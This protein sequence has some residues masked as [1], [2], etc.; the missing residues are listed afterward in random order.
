MG[1]KPRFSILVAAYNV[2]KYIGECL[3]SLLV[4]TFNDYEVVVIDD[5][6]TDETN[7][8]CRRY[9]ELEEKIKLFSWENHGLVMSRRLGISMALGEYIL[10]LDAD[11]YHIGNSLER[12]N[13]SLKEN[14][15][16]DIMMF[17][18]EFRYANGD[19]KESTLFENI[20]YH[21]TNKRQLFCDLV[22][23]YEYNH[24]WCKVIK[25]QVILQDTCDYEKF[26]HIKLG[27]DLLQTI[28]VFDIAENVSICSHVCYG[29]RILENSMS[30][31][32]NEK[33][34][35]DISEVYRYFENYISKHHKD[36]DNVIQ[37]LYSA[38]VLK[39]IGLLRELW[40]SSLTLEEKKRL[41]K[42]ICNFRMFNNNVHLSNNLPLQNKMLFFMVEKKNW[43]LSALYSEILK[44]I[45]GD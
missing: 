11:D 42:I 45:R 9:S 1:K 14:K 36:Y 19:K 12:I 23:N 16:P 39:M 5:G 31:N 4:Q 37:E 21:K 6:S 35:Y 17:R 34:L 22:H 26:A 43:R 44:K 7:R 40:E 13:K 30:H 25:R 24:L 41:S 33:Q 38:Y 28:P 2:E 10:F 29:Y 27:E 18:F 32:F 20:T 3:D 15:E 8:I